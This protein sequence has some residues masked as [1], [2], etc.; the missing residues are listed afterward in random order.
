[1]TEQVPQKKTRRTTQKALIRTELEA[2]PK[3]M[4]AQQL[5][6]KLIAAGAAVGIA[7]VYRQLGKLAEQGEIDSIQ[8]ENGVLFRAC[9]ID[10]H[11]H[12]MVCERCGA[13]FAFELPQEPWLTEQAEA[14]GFKISRHVIEVFGLCAD[15]QRA[16][17]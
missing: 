17:S 12:H 15:C 14:H 6:Q 8:T 2:E 5:H 16:A 10:G 7:T 13:A 3:F 9:D 1:M 11:H 4:T